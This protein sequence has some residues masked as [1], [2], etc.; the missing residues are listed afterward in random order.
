MIKNIS[1]FYF[2]FYSI[3]T[4]LLTKNDTR[5]NLPRS[6]HIKKNF[7]LFSFTTIVVVDIYYYDY[8][9]SIFIIN[10]KMY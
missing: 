1:K 7:L 10:N 4:N 8:Y 9:Y 5:D 3:F 2:Y 6:I